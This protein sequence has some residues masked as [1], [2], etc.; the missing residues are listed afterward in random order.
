MNFK[1]WYYYLY[2]FI[3]EKIIFFNFYFLP[4]IDSLLIFFKLI[5]NKKYIFRNYFFFEKIMGQFPFIKKMKKDEIYLY[6]LTL[7]K[8]NLMRF[9]NLFIVFFSH[10]LDLFINKNY[11]YNIIFFNMKLYNIYKKF[12]Y[13]L[14]TNEKIYFLFIFKNKIKNIKLYDVFFNLFLKK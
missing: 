2:F 9:L 14:K 12:N 11:T 7:R 8:I 1:F 5:K 6:Q 13:I 10:N 3:I 4:Y